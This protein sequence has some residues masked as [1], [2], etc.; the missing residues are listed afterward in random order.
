MKPIKKIVIVGGGSS[1]WIA[2]SILAHD[3]RP[4][5]L[6]V[7]LVESEEIGTIGVGES[8]VPPFVGLIKK[9]GID[10]QHFIQ[11]VHA[12][13]KLGI[14]LPDWHQV[15]ESYFHPFGWIGTRLGVHDFYQAWLK[16]K[17][18]GH[19]SELQSFAPCSVMA[20]ERRFFLPQDAPPRTPLGSAGYAL[21]IDASLVAKYLRQYAEERK[22]RR[23]EG[24]VT[25]VRQNEDG[26][27]ASLL[28]KSGEEVHGDFFID[29]TG[30]YALLI[31]KS[32][33]IGYEDWLNYLP[34][35]RA[36]AVQ[37]ENLGEA[38]PYTVATAREEGW[39]WRIPL[40]HRTG[41][42]YVYSS[43]YCSDDEATA[44][45]LSYVDG[46]PITEPMIIPFRTGMRES[47]WHKNCISI[48]LS[49]GFIEPLEATALHLVMRGM[50]FFLRFYPDQDCEQVLVDEYN[51]YMRSE[52]ELIRDFI[53]LHYCLT[54]R[55]DT[56]F[57]KHCKHMDIPP[58]LAEKIE[59]FEA[60]GI[61]RQGDDELWQASSWQSVFEG[62]G[63]RP[64][65]YSARIDNLD[66]PLLEEK[67]Q[68]MEMAISRMAR[69]L[70]T[71]DQ[72]IRERFSAK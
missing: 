24:L 19:T 38:V 21:H 5:V 70:P 37:T 18:K 4:E 57:W 66:Y 65:K 28:L 27:I 23:T 7:E 59:L 56:P 53:V 64:K 42:G 46:K 40:Q 12:T 44:K 34:C 48:G 68:E 33:G 67:L 15:G 39:S 50:E 41:N 6:E 29:C 30:F 55:E 72:F 2:A 36:V 9:L 10:E 63:V 3:F 32:L 43:E 11:N 26:S 71:H 58:G 1:G 49:S 54:D 45:L 62:M 16:A 51:R 8:T 61:L 17:S 31:E 35:D 13:F 20:R 14:E 47:F 52:Y 69:R 25:E 22:V 60:Q